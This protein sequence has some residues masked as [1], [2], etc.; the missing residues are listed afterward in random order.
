MY[1]SNHPP[2]PFT[3]E[4]C[5]L[6]HGQ[7]QCPDDSPGVPIQDYGMEAIIALAII[8]YLII[9]KKTYQL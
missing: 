8:T 1:H 9:K 6:H 7:G 5:K 2:K 3:D 4:W